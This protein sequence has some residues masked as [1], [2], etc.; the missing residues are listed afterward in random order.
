MRSEPS[1]TTSKVNAYVCPHIHHTIFEIWAQNVLVSLFWGCYSPN[2]IQRYK[3]TF[4]YRN[5]LRFIILIKRFVL[6]SKFGQKKV[7]FLQLAWLDTI[8][9]L[10]FSGGHCGC[11][12]CPVVSC[13]LLSDQII[14]SWCLPCSSDMHV[15]L[16]SHIRMTHWL[17]CLAK[18]SNT[19]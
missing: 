11:H 15:E 18:D 6:G 9:P 1:K 14:S 13:H 4:F 7:K 12:T 5:M 19:E 17:L 8:S 10:N 3:I 16:R 2:F